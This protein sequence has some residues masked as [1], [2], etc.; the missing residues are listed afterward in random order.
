MIS[1]FSAK[2]AQAKAKTRA[3]QKASPSQPMSQMLSQPMSQNARRGFTLIELLV[4]IAIIAILAAILFP[5]FAAARESAR[6]ISCASN[7]RQ[8]TISMAQ[9]TQEYDE[10]YPSTATTSFPVLLNADIKSKN[11]FVCP[12]ATDADSWTV[13][14]PVGPPTRS[15]Y[16]VNSFLT[17]P[18]ISLGEV[19]S[20][21]STAMFFDCNADYAGD[22]AGLSGV[23]A[24]HRRV[25]NVAYADGH[26]KLFRWD[27]GA[28]EINFIP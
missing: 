18:P 17:A 10:K 4:V 6:R 2:S 5:A 19:Q 20:P 3:R 13:T 9:Y 27:A 12:S 7:L 23:L 22:I 14:W 16:G 1:Y 28:T 15:S 24:R 26:V 8:I 25:V 21:A 11:I